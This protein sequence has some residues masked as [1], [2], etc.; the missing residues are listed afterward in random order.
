VRTDY[1]KRGN[2]GRKLG[3]IPGLSM[4]IFLVLRRA[5]L[6][7]MCRPTSDGGADRGACPTRDLYIPSD[8]KS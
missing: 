4:M 1:T 7:L 3:I 5:P 6:F 2:N 8:S